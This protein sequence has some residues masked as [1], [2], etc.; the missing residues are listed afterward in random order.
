MDG[1]AGLEPIGTSGLS[2]IAKR[3]ANSRLDCTKI[4]RV[5]AFAYRLA[6]SLADCLDALSSYHAAETSR[7]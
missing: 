3:P 5:S 7:C 4:R 6:S 2:D 1:G